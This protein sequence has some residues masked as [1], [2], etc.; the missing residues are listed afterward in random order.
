MSELKMSSSASLLKG[1]C[2]FAPRDIVDVMQGVNKFLDENPTETVVFIYQVNNDVDQ[3]VDLNSFYGQLLLVDGLVEKLYVHSDAGTPWPTLRQQ[4]DPAFN[5]RIIMFHYN[6][7]DCT[8]S[9]NLCPAALM[10]YYGYASD[11]DWENLSVESIENRSS[12]CVLK[13]NGINSKTFI[14]LNNFVSPPSKVSARK[15][16]DYTAVLD[17]VDSC[18][19]LL[20]T[21]INFLLVD[22]WGEGD[23]PRYTQ[24]HNTALIARGL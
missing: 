12:S 10:N 21:D 9:P 17:Y 3:E 23:V 16:N 18:T 4:T 22:Y 20:K 1:I 2:S 5:K 13:K 15:L 11:N 6:G 14:G 19:V 8:A 24:D 7:P